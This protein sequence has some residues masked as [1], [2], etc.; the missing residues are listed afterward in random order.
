MEKL[1]VKRFVCESSLGIGDSKGQLGPLY[2]FVL[3]PL[4]LRNIFADKE[5][6]EK[7][8]QESPLDWVIARP[9]RLTN[10]PHTGKYRSGFAADGSSIRAKISRAD[11]ADFMLQQL[12]SDDSLRKT[13][14]IS[15]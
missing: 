9:A 2:N 10:G 5:V 6:Q 12:S 8:I 13:P 4:L 14:G 11:V 7:L 15:Y 3:I 1:G